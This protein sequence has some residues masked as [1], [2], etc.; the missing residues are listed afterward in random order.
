MVVFVNPL[1][2]F[3]KKTITLLLINPQVL[4]SRSFDYLQ[5]NVPSSP[6]SVGLSVYHANLRPPRSS[7]CADPSRPTRSACTHSAD[8]TDLTLYATTSRCGTLMAPSPEVCI[9]ATLDQLLDVRADAKARP[10]YFQKFH[11]LLVISIS[12]R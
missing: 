11:Q 10:V 12:E 1:S 4:H 8:L 6:F 7:T 9:T 2:I 5:K 3:F